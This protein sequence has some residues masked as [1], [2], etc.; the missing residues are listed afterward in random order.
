MWI[1][2]FFG[3]LQCRGR[4]HANGY[5]YIKICKCSRF[6]FIGSLVLGSGGK[7]G[8]EWGRFFILF[9]SKNY[10]SLVG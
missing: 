6:A 2:V 10:I 7:G 1:V 3:S 5:H 4:G 9:F 8:V